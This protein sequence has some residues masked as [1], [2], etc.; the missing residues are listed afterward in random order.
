MNQAM[1][2]LIMEYGIPLAIELFKK[3]KQ[4]H[5][6]RVLEKIKASTKAPEDVLKKLDK[7]PSA[8]AGV[9]GILADVFEILKTNN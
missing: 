7:E 4:E 8:K 3:R 6:A 1:A 2:Y 5:E 9:I